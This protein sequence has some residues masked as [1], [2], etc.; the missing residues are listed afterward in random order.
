[1][2]PDTFG[3]AVV[4]MRKQVETFL[5]NKRYPQAAFRIRAFRTAIQ[6]L[7]L[8]HWLAHQPAG[9]HFYWSSRDDDLEVAALGVADRV[10]MRDTLQTTSLIETIGQRI[11]TQEEPV[12]YY[13]GMRFPTQGRDPAW[14]AFGAAQFI[15]PRVEIR[16]E[17][18][19][20]TLTVYIVEPE[21]IVQWSRIGEQLTD[22][23]WEAASPVA[24]GILPIAREDRPERL[25]WNRQIQ[26]ALQAFEQTS[27]EKVVLARRVRFVFARRL[28]PFFLLERLKRETSHCFHFLF[29]PRSGTAFLGASPE[30]LYRREGR[31]L[32]TEAVAGTRPRGVSVEEDAHLAEALLNSAKDQYE[33]YLVVERIRKGLLP[34]CQ[35]LQ[36]EPQAQLMKLARKQHLYTPFRGV[37]AEG[38]SDRDI[39]QAIYPT[40][41]VGG[42]PMA[43]ALRWIAR[44]EPFD[45]GW[46][47][48]LVGYI[49]HQ[50][51]E[52][53]VGI[54]CGLVHD[55]VL[56][57]FS[58]AGI[59]KGST[60]DAEWEEIEHKI[61]DFLEILT[62][63]A[64]SE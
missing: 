10:W 58:G 15:L 28:Q 7:N 60:P 48:G 57:L 31:Q 61:S 55:G 47:T 24:E 51:T 27:L 17:G 41:A 54:R 64:T 59:V 11:A 52:F 29:S 42:E 9:P 39:V 26:R 36:V 8:L 25:L 18:P 12:V 38:V 14:R 19:T 21:D 43:E 44:A 22:L 2:A 56:D 5:G 20:Y 13:G 33:H 63:E 6:P 46:Y 50:I 30:R 1:M 4:R 40:P 35:E 32:L 37:L 23:V 53:A 45:R 16:R 3:E 49:S 62:A 34:L